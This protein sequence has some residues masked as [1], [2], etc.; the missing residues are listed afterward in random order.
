MTISEAQ[1]LLAKI[2]KDHGDVEVFFDCPKC[3]QAFTPAKVATKAVVI[4]AAVTGATP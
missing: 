1:K 4:N 2:Q 3:H